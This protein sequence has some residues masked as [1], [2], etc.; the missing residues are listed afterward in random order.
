MLTILLT[1]KKGVLSGTLNAAI[2]DAIRDMPGRKK[3]KDRNLVFE[4]TEANVSY[5][6]RVFPNAQWQDEADRLKEIEALRQLEADSRQRKVMALPADP[7]DFP[8]K[9]KPYDHQLRIFNW[10]KDRDYLALFA[11]M[12]CGKSKS[13]IDLLA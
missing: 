11:E 12:G 10:G 5:L 7:I 1:E 4:P 8:F 3:W 2:M 13:W 9:T 6:R